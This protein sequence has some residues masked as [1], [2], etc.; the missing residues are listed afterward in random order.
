M[1]LDSMKIVKTIR[2]HSEPVNTLLV[3]K[4]G[5]FVS[6]S[7]GRIIFYSK[8]NFEVILRIT[9]F[10]E[11]YFSHIYEL[12]IDNIFLLSYSGFKIIQTTNDNKKYKVLF[13]FYERFIMN[14]AI[15]Y[16]YKYISKD[17]KETIKYNIL[18]SSVYGIHIFEKTE[19]NEKNDK[20]DA[21]SEKNDINQKIKIESDNS[22]LN[23][24]FVKKLN[25]NEIIYNI[26]QISNNC[27]ISTS[28]SVLASGNNCLR[29]WSYS[30][31]SNFKTINNLY[32][33]SGV[34]SVA[35]VEN[36]LL[37]GLE[38]I[39]KYL[40]RSK[41]IDDK[42]NIN[43]IAVIDLENYEVV[44][45][46]ETHNCIRSLL[47]A[48]NNTIIVGSTFNLLQYRFNRGIM[49]KIGE[50]ELFN[51]IN[52]VIIEVDNNTFVTGSNDKKIIVIK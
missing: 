9:E 44:Q 8:E 42:L 51:Y 22:D 37:V 21:N 38:K 20:I 23:Y 36:M 29:F 16:E 24:T 43:G 17:N 6:G 31:M 28:N 2:T 33:S 1:S 13:S 39:P 25:F 41:I 7:L 10:K 52:N 14:K 34:N 18:I 32:C 40:F 4:N 11:Y 46:I 49:E 15:E 45:F 35:K 5:N 27:F 47:L 48:K 19:K 26:L 50:K 3:C 12:H 30:E